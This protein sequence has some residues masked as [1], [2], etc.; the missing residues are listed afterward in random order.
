M[1]NQLTYTELKKYFEGAIE[2]DELPVTLEGTYA[3]YPYLKQTIHTIIGKIDFE[4]TRHGREKIKSSQV[5]VNGKKKLLQIY[6]DLQQPERWNISHAE[7]S[8]KEIKR[9]F[10]NNEK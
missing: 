2:R 5:A 3:F 9:L 4:F 10:N 7:F 1:E 8:E 6:K